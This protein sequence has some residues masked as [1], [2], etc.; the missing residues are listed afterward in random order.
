MNRLAVAGIACAALLGAWVVV[1]WSDPGAPVL[2]P[3]PPAPPMA[4]PDA[5]AVPPIP[6][7]APQP[8]ARSVDLDDAAG[9]LARRRQRTV[10]IDRAAN[11]AAGS[12]SSEDPRQERLAQPDARW[13]GNAGSRWRSIGRQLRLDAVDDPDLIDDVDEIVEAYRDA[14]RDPDR[15]APDTLF[16][17]QDALMVRIAQQPSRSDALRN[18]LGALQADEAAFLA[19]TRDLPASP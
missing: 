4:S 5:G 12:A 19:A 9:R 10:V 13:Y 6:P 7:P 16:K 8:L 18:L 2:P 15:A 1:T 3:P 14:R 17:A 11:Q